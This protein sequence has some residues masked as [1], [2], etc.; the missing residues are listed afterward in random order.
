TLISFFITQPPPFHLIRHFLLWPFSTFSPAWLL[1]LP[2]LRFP[3]SLWPAFS[4][5]ILFRPR[6]RLLLRLS[7][8]LFWRPF[9]SLSS[10]LPLRPHRFSH[11]SD[12]ADRSILRSPLSRSKVFRDRSDHRCSDR[13]C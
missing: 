3:L 9:S 13:S 1:R 7:L 8:R 10:V 6:F 4:A 11:A 12:R 5:W 2:V